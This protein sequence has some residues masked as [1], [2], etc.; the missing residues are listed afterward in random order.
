MNHNKQFKVYGVVIGV[1]VVAGISYGIYS[2]ITTTRRLRDVEYE[3]GSSIEKVSALEKQNMELGGTLSLTQSEKDKLNE[4]LT[5][6]KEENEELEEERDM[7]EKL[8]KTDKQLLAKYSKVYFLNENYSP[9]KLD[10]ID[11]KYVLPVGKKREFLDPALPYL[12]DLL[13]DAE[14]DGIQLRV[15]SAYRSFEEQMALK[16]SYTITYGAGTANA[17]SADQGYSEHQLGTTVD[18]GTP[19]VPGAMGAFANTTAYTWLLE[20]GHKYGFI[21]SY[22]KANSY[23]MY[24]PWHW[25]FVGEDLAR[26]LY[27][28]K[29]NFYDLDQRKIDDYLI[30]IFD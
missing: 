4:E 27:K 17:F 9:V 15:V 3:L 26:Y 1:L 21:L 8:A 2:L 11:A 30:K 12:E 29:L 14:E 28:K 18:F 20:N 7:F 10:E 24:E 6:Q 25:R 13:E 16:S 19:A 5:E 22:P 23:Y